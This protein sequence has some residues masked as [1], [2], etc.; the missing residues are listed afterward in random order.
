MRDE[1]SGDA[2]NSCRSIAAADAAAFAFTA[3]A[4]AAGLVASAGPAAAFSLYV[5]SAAGL[6]RFDTATGVTSFIGETRFA[7]APGLALQL[8]DV[9][10]EFASDGTLWAMGR[11]GSTGRAVATIDLATGLATRF[12]DH[13]F[14]GLEGLAF[15]ED[16]F[17]A[18]RG[19]SVGELAEIA[20]A[21]LGGLT[22]TTVLGPIA[23]GDVD[24]LTTAP[25]DV[26]VA[27]FGTL[28]AGTLVAVD[29]QDLWAVDLP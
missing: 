9:A 20:P 22:G 14:D 13:A 16:G 1:R 4:A 24:G 7:T 28:A 27:G 29:T 23:A 19:S 6:E 18:G 2:P 15:I 10:L 3:A 25:V 5:E 17:V 8:E 12:A 26:T 11:G 21:P